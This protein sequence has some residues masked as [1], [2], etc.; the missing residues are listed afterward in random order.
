MAN[1]DRADQE[2]TQETRE[3]ASPRGEIELTVTETGSS[4]A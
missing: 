3:F 4:S 1:E 2:D